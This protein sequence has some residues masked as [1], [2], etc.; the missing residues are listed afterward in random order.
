LAFGRW[1]FESG[2]LEIWNLESKLESGIWNLESLLFRPKKPKH[3]SIPKQSKSLISLCF[4]DPRKNYALSES[5]FCGTHQPI[6][7][8]TYQPKKLKAVEPLE[9]NAIQ[10]N[11][12]QYLYV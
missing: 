5:L 11:K 3:L 2:N 12:K 9:Q 8:S 1:L 10:K 6:N 7:L 4:V